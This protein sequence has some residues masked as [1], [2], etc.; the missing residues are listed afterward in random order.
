MKIYQLSNY[1]AVGAGQGS[2]D[3]FNNKLLRFIFFKVGFDKA[4]N[5]SLG[6]IC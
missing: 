4:F 2:Y 3:Q 5:F 1:L 6:L